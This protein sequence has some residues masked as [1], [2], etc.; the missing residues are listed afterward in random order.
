M[1]KF[2]KAFKDLVKDEALINELRHAYQKGQ[3]R[4]DVL[5]S[6][7]HQGEITISEYVEIIKDKKK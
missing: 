1:G 7:L 5:V 4:A 3:V 6:M 2:K